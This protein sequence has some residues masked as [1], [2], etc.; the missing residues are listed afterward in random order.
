MSEYF[1]V[2]ENCMFADAGECLDKFPDAGPGCLVVGN[3]VA[4]DAL[5]AEL[6]DLKA[7]MAHKDGTIE[8]LMN[9]SAD[10]LS[11]L[12]NVDPEGYLIIA[13]S[14]GLLP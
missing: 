14:A 2:P 5:K 6:A 12:K 7:L 3:H 13:R 9:I 8:K 10:L 1:W 11:H 4:Y